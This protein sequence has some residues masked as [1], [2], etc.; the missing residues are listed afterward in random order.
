MIDQLKARLNLKAVLRNLEL[1]PE[2][3]DLSRELIKDWEI[4]IRLS[5]W[6]DTNILLNFHNGRCTF[7]ADTI[8]KGTVS[9]FFC[10]AAHLNNMMENNASPLPLSGFTRLGFLKTEFSKLTSRLEYFL[11]PPSDVVQDDRFKMINLSLALSTAV[12]AIPELLQLD[13]V[14]RRIAPQLSAGTLQLSVLPEGPYAHVIYDGKGGAKAFTG[15]AAH[16]DALLSFRNPEIAQ[17][18]VDG[19]LDSFGAVAKGDIQLRGKIPLIDHTNVIL[20]QIPK[21]LQ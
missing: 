21:Y 4:S 9:L 6:R 15:K 1:L 19:T 13:P 17:L 2:I 14:S 7:L 11:K 5:I 12:F 20:D 3:D 16:P 18:L 10:S 8:E